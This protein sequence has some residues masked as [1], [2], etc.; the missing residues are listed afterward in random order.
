MQYN[1]RLTLGTLLLWVNFVGKFGIVRLRVQLQ[2]SKILVPEMSLMDSELF[3][4]F[5]G[6]PEY[7]ADVRHP[8]VWISSCKLEH[9]VVARIYLVAP[10]LVR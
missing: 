8:P 5:I 7:S 1:A 4:S 6:L 3:P 2:D 9:I 10:G